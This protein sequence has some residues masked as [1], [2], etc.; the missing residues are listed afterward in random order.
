MV[1]ETLEKAG[2]GRRPTLE[3]KLESL[4]AKLKRLE[5][6][7]FENAAAKSEAIARCKAGIDELQ[8][9]GAAAKQEG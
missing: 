3:R 9:A 7:K 4:Q 2:P 6:A 1:T 8:Q 5:T